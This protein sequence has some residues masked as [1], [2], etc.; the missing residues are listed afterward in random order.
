MNETSNDFPE[1]LPRIGCV[2]V[3]WN[4]WQDT[5]ECLDSL[6]RQTYTNLEVIV[7]DNGSTND[8]VA[9]ILSAHPW[10]HLHRTEKNLGFATGC[11]E[12]TR[13]ACQRRA[14]YIWLLNNDTVAPPDSAAKLVE[15]ALANPRAGA[16]G[17][18]LYYKHDPSRV[19]AW[20][21]GK[22]NLWLGF[23]SHFYQPADLRRKDAFLT[24]ASLL[25]PRTICNEVGV[26]YE[27]FFMYCDDS[28]LCLRIHRAGYDLVAA[29]N[30]AILHKEGGSSPSRSPLIDQF[31][32][33]SMIR[34]LL[35]NA[36]APAVSIA[37]YLLLRSANR[38]V[39]GR[40]ENLF[41]VWRGVLIAIRERHQHFCD[42]L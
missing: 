6:K 10:V 7:V 32:T 33:T 12:G 27:G 20:G 28:D 31:A 8:S 37:A 14:D 41:A 29:S 18:I 1:R 3:N 19:Q 36:P 42:R 40:L 15:T 13:A 39:H 38:L 9:R 26:F 34:F 11:N 16:V 24:G 21:G 25:L 2:L 5:V 30:T 23:V 35:R 4:G 22:V 17:S